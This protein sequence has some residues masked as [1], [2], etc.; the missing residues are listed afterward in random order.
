MKKRIRDLIIDG[1]ILTSI[2]GLY[3][4]ILFYAKQ[5]EDWFLTFTFSIFGIGIIFILSCFVTADICYINDEKKKQKKEQERLSVLSPYKNGYKLRV[6]TC[7]YS[8]EQEK[9]EHIR[10]LTYKQ[11]KERYYDY[12]IVKVRHNI[13]INVDAFGYVIISEFYMRKEGE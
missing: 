3:T 2:I 5:Y 9:V 12:K 1:T 8:E 6:R 11:T 10:K 7:V 4:Y 13:A